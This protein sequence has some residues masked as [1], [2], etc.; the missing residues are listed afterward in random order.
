MEDNIRISQRK[1]SSLEQQVQL[2][3]DALDSAT[4]EHSSIDKDLK[5]MH[6]KAQGLYCHG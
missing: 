4:R 2:I 5:K 6:S 3:E 1:L